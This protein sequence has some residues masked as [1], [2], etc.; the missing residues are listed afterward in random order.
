MVEL[1]LEGRSIDLKEALEFGNHMRATKKP[2]L[3]KKLVHK[4]ITHVYNPVLPMSKVQCILCLL[5]APM[6]I[7][8][9]NT[10]NKLGRIVRNDCLTYDRSYKWSPG[11]TMNSRVDKDVLFPC[12]LGACLNHIFNWTTTARKTYPHQQILATK[13]DYKSAYQRCC[14]NTKTA[15]QTYTQLPDQNLA[16]MAPRLTLG[17]TPGPHEWGVS[18]ETVHNLATYILQHDD[19]DPEVSL[20]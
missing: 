7:Q 12:M 20:L 3:L 6:N 4:Y 8:K 19:W 10:I 2:E 17:G 13:T 15:I 18:S 5:M 14:L 1:D 9:Q 11:T 16:I